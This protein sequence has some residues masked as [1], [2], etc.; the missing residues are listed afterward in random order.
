MGKNYGPGNVLGMT[1]MPHFVLEMKIID[2][3][4]LNSKSDK[5]YEF[6]LVHFGKRLLQQ[7]KMVLSSLCDPPQWQNN[8]HRFSFTSVTCAQGETTLIGEKHRVPVVDRHILI[9]SQL[10][11]KLLLGEK[12]NHLL[13]VFY[14]TVMIGA[15]LKTEV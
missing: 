4:R 12:Q 2:L 1:R 13:K 9:F 10:F 15:V 6:R 3:Q 11:F 5:N 8:L 14:R 7:L